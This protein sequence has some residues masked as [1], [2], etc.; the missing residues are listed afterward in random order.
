[1]TKTQNH[2]KNG[3][4]VMCLMLLFFA[5]FSYGQE[6]AVVKPSLQSDAEMYV[7]NVN[8]HAKDFTVQMMNGE[9]IKLSDLRGKVV[10]LNFWATWCGPCM[11]EFQEIPSKIVE[12]FKN[13]AFVLLPV[14]RGETM[15]EVKT[16]MAQLKKDGIDFNV[17]I[18]P[19]RKIFDQYA[20]QGIPKNFL[21]DK[22]GIIRH[23]CTG[24][25]QESVQE[26]A[27]LIKKMLEE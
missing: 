23:V 11:M 16:K 1:M 13:S 20:T 18:D 26:I 15:D 14:S 5:Y 12:P 7:L 9:A 2:F 17:G 27:S 24:Y 4:I 8:D 3:R 6:N 22:N 10:L 25:S 21:I 19:D